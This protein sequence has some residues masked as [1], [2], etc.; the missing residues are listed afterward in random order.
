M[1]RR[2]FEEDKLIK[3][4]GAFYDLRV[5]LPPLAR[6]L[7]TQTGLIMAIYIVGFQVVYNLDRTR[8][9]SRWGIELDDF[10]LDLR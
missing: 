3:T 8:G 6:I 10:R 7:Y 4:P 5:W 1:E 2:L 9:R